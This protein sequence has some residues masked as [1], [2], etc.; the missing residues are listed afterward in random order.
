L[1]GKWLEYDGNLKYSENPECQW[2]TNPV[3]LFNC[4]TLKPDVG[5]VILLQG[6]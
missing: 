1:T 4:K 5:Q 6:R 3:A 2:L